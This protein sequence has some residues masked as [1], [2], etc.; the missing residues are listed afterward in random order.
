MVGTL[1]LSHQRRAVRRAVR[2]QCLVVRQRDYRLIGSAGMDLSPMGML[3]KAHERVLTG[4]PV[5][6]SF[7]LPRSRAWVSASA[8]IA[9]VLHGRRPG[10]TGRCLGLEFDALEPGLLRRLRSALHNVPPPLPNREPRVDYAA[11]VYL[12]ALS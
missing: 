11:S 7:R 2:V 5:R 8:T 4:E 6:V 12:A 10:D 1:V 3:V 9:R